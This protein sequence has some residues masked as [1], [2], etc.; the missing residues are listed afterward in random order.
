MPASPMDS[1]I[2]SNSFSDPDVAPLFSDVAEVAAMAA[3]EAALARAQAAVGVI[4][5]DAVAPI[6]EAVASFSA[7]L[8]AMGASTGTSGVPTISLVAQLR[9]GGRQHC[10]GFGRAQ[11]RYQ[12]GCNGYRAVAAAARRGWY[13][14]GAA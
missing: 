14:V 1:T 9:A 5:V 12:P 13:L 2:Y 7:D 6:E 4:P 8:A 3:F 11:G 10:G